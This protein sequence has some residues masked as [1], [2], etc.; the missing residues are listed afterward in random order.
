ML[1]TLGEYGFVVHRTRPVWTSRASGV[2][3]AGARALAI[4]DNGRVQMASARGYRLSTERW[5]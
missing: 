2:A 3:G 5:V 4:G 1:N